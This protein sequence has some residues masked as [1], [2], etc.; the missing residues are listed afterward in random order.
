V[1]CGRCQARFEPEDTLYMPC[2]ECG[3][4]FGHQVVEGKEL[5]VANIEADPAGDEAAKE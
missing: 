1:V 2:P 3:L 4:E 5:F